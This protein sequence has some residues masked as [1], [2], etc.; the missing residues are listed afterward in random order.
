MEKVL[1][2]PL[3]PVSMS[4]SCADG[5]RCKTTK[6]KLF[7][8]SL[9]D[10]EIVQVTLPDLT[11]LPHNYLDI[12]ASVRTFIQY[13]EAIRGLS[14]VGTSRPGV[15]SKKVLLKISQLY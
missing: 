1:E 9:N 13:C 12:A 4:L 14:K 10:M 15:F 2:Y 7:C 5:T 11:T 6:S 3:T 8:A